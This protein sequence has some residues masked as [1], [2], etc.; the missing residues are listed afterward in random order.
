MIESP[1]SLPFSGTK[2]FL[3]YTMLKAKSKGF[4][5]STRKGPETEYTVYKG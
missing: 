2:A 4:C 3:F 1:I 5:F